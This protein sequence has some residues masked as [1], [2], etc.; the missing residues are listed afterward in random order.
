MLR[1]RLNSISSNVRTSRRAGL[2]YVQTNHA[3]DDAQTHNKLN[4]RYGTVTRSQ[5]MRSSPCDVCPQ[6][7]VCATN[8]APAPSPQGANEIQ[9]GQKIWIEDEE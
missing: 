7:T 3:F 6:M 9:Q 2:S 1:H 8:E 5:C 4:P